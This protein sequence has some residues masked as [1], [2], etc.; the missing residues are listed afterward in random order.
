MVVGKLYESFRGSLMGRGSQIFWFLNSEKIPTPHEIS[1]HYTHL[2]V[3][4][5]LKRLRDS[6]QRNLKK[7]LLRKKKD[8]KSD[9]EKLF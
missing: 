4:S 2:S 6:H 5:E 8:I 1:H 3:N 9:Q 7:E